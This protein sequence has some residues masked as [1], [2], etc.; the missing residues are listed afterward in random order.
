MHSYALALKDNTGP[1]HAVLKL[2]LWLPTGCLLELS[3]RACTV[4]GQLQKWRSRSHYEGLGHIRRQA[5]QVR[6][7]WEESWISGGSEI[8]GVSSSLGIISRKGMTRAH[9]TVLSATTHGR[10]C[11]AW[12]GLHEP[13]WPVMG[14]PWEATQCSS[15][16]SWIPFTVSVSP[17]P[18]SLEPIFLHCPGSPLANDCHVDKLR[19]NLTP[20][21]P[22]TIRGPPCCPLQL[23]SFLPTLLQISPRNASLTNYLPPVLVSKPTSG[24]PNLGHVS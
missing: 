20:E 17:T 19:F 4:N 21:S 18:Q 3:D 24:K 13:I 10:G 1:L 16:I 8:I 23:T 14:V 6:G 5:S 2:C 7:E 12:R 11:A 9:P 22:F 15:P